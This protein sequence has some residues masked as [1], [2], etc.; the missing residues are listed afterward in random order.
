[1]GERSSAC[2]VGLVVTLAR[3]ISVRQ[4]GG[5][6]WGRRGGEDLAPSLWGC[7][8]VQGRGEALRE[9]EAEAG[10]KQ[11]V[12]KSRD[13][14]WGLRALSLHR[15]GLPC[16]SEFM[17]FRQAWL[18]HRQRGPYSLLHLVHFCSI[19]VALESSSPP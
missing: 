14:G 9:V 8:A 19:P 7:L 4:W 12:L 13:A 6:R 3:A 16:L 10:A 2:S 1:M 18:P 15:E 11:E 17:A 5:G